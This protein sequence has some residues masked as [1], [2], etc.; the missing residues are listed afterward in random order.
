MSMPQSVIFIKDV[1][2]TDG[3]RIFFSLHLVPSKFIA[4]VKLNVCQLESF[5]NI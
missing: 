2:L 3:L 5:S 1:L 4:H